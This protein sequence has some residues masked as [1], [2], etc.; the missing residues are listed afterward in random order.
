MSRPL[1][2]ACFEACFI[3]CLISPPDEEG[4]LDFNDLDWLPE[5]T[6]ASL[7]E[8]PPAMAK[9]RERGERAASFRT[10]AKRGLNACFT[11]QNLASLNP[12]RVDHGKLRAGWS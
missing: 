9:L 7:F 3:A 1:L 6:W 8:F 12:A 10:L 11:K 2:D 4:V 5:A